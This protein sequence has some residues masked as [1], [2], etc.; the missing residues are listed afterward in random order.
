MFYILYLLYFTVICRAIELSVT[1]STVTNYLDDCED[2]VEDD[3]QIC[4]TV[5]S[6]EC[7][8]K[9]EDTFKPAKVE[10][11]QT[12]KCN[13]EGLR[14]KC[15]TD[16]RTKCGTKMVYREVV[17][18]HPV[19]RDEQEEQCV[20]QQCRTV[21]KRK[22][23]IEKR[24]T[25]KGIPDTSC[26]RVPRRLCWKETCKKQRCQEKMVLNKE[27]VPREECTVQQK[28]ICET[29]QSDSCRQREGRK[30]GRSK[31]KIREMTTQYTTEATTPESTENPTSTLRG[32]KIPK[33][34]EILSRPIYQ[35]NQNLVNKNLN[36]SKIVYTSSSNDNSDDDQMET[37]TETDDSLGKYDSVF[38][39][40]INLSEIYENKNNVVDT[41]TDEPE[42]EQEAETVKSRVVEIIKPAHNS[43]FKSN[44][45]IIV[46][47]SS[48]NISFNSL[49]SMFVLVMCSVLYIFQ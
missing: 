41:E 6:K 31:Q 4:R 16:Y 13:E 39:S 34:L 43:P 42:T 21:T 3:C 14:E 30:C 2:V 32:R 11:C 5:L 9:M 20:E 49:N 35:L 12:T 1:E 15:S 26:S 25:R 27:T 8:I 45:E 24:K 38:N 19:C 44:E 17:E 36:S 7:F 10:E 40:H 29:V 47:E 33:R 23:K 46:I 18:D 37:E 48:S 28:L 22:C